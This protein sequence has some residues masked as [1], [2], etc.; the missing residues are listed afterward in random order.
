MQVRKWGDSLAIE[1]PHDVVETLQ[2]REGDEI[3]I[4][5]PRKGVAEME[6]KPTRQELIESLRQ[7]RGMM[8]ADFKFNRDEANER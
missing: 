4:T 1:L 6:R 5:T 7:F 3:E 2:L 8:P